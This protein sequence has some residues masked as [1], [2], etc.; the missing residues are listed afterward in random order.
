MVAEHLADGLGFMLGF[1]GRADAIAEPARVRLADAD[2]ALV[3]DER[4]SLVPDDQEPTAT[5]VA[6]PE[7]VLRLIAGRL[8]PAHTPAD[9]AV[10]GNVTLDDLRRVF[11]GY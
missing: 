7:A 9:V 10:T 1:I 3:I 5:L 2:A 11:P 6:D 8:G 4:V